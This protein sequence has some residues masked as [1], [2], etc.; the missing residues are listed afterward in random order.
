MLNPW[1]SAVTPGS[2]NVRPTPTPALL[3]R[4]HFEIGMKNITLWLLPV[5]IAAS[6]AQRAQA[7]FDGTP[8]QHVLASG[9]AAGDR[10]G[11]AVALSANTLA[12]GAPGKGS[13]A[14]TVFERV[15]GLWQFA[16]ELSASGLDDDA[17]FGFAL[18]LQADR[19]LVGAPGH[20]L[21]TPWKRGV[22]FVFERGG[23]GAWNQT[24]MLQSAAVGDHNAFGTALALD[25]DRAA[26]GAPGAPWN[27]LPQVGL[28]SVF[29]LAAGAWTPSATVGPSDAWI[30]YEFGA[31]VALRAG[32][33]VVGAPR[34]KLPSATSFDA[35]VYT[36]TFGAS[37][38]T[39]AQ[40]LTDTLPGDRLDQLGRSLAFDGQTIVAGSDGQWYSSYSAQGALTFERSG[41]QWIAKQRLTSATNS[42]AGSAVAVEGDTLV[43]GARNSGTSAGV[44]G[45]AASAWTLQP[46][47]WSERVRLLDSAPQ[48]TAECGAAIAIASGQLALGSPGASVNAQTDVGVVLV[49]DA[50]TSFGEVLCFGDGSGASCPC[51]AH[52]ATTHGP[53]CRN[54]SGFGTLLVGGGSASVASDDL[55]LTAVRL[56]AG[57]TAVLVYRFGAA[58]GGAGV[59]LHDGLLCV[60]G[61]GG[62][63][64]SR[65]ASV[66]PFAAT[67]GPGLGAQLG[68]PSGTSVYFQVW[69]R[70]PAGACGSG[71]NFSNA[72]RVQLTP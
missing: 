45:G 22:A 52:V 51:A 68:A 40:I 60:S 19:L 15:G 25:G 70:D 37:G 20:R 50:P 33:L 31:S 67:W 53:G 13:G 16:A 11:H 59:P 62:R 6:S 39:Q 8:A 12:V 65:S 66:F 49:F 36:F 4:A 35:A 43:L 63:L 56:P 34:R 26:I 58:N 57:K 21:G 24:A 2:H 1:R 29:E 5:L 72:F 17:E 32:E 69:Y 27:S 42:F 14:V 46:S 9:G 48:S 55:S 10:F 3:A 38:W 41:S 64:G 71:S 30:N 28:V 18:A 61:A 7:Q 44:S 54:S 47:G 23:A